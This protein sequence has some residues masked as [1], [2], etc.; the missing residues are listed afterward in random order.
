MK[1]KTYSKLLMFCAAC[2]AGPALAQ[3]NDLPKA[4]PAQGFAPTD[5][6]G[7]VPGDYENARAN[8]ST[9]FKVIT[10]YR[11]RHHGMYTAKVAALLADIA[12]APASYQFAS[13]QAANSALHNP[14]AKF[15]DGVSAEEAGA[16]WVYRLVDKRPDGTAFGTPHETGTKDL[17]AYTSA[18]I[19]QNVRYFPG[20][21][22]VAN[23]VGSYV[24]LW[25]DGSIETF[26]YDQ[27]LFAPQEDG[28]FSEVFPGQAGIPWNVLTYDEMLPGT[29]RGKPL[30]ENR[31][32]AVPDNGAP[33]ALLALSRLLGHPLDREALW[34][35]L[36]PLQEQFNPADIGNTAVQLG[37]PLQRASLSWGDLQQRP[38]PAI[39]SLKAPERLITLCSIGQDYS[40][41]LDGGMKRIVKNSALAARYKG[42]ALIVPSSQETSPL[43]IKD[44]VG[45]ITIKPADEVKQ[46]VRIVNRGQAP[47]HLDLEYPI[48]G[49]VQAHLSQ[50]SIA[51]GEETVLD[52]SFKWRPPVSGDTQ[53]D[54]ITLHTDAPGQ[55]RVQCGFVLQLEPE[56]TRK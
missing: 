16:V 40:I 22:S 28:A 39:L 24:L 3:P 8:L 47:V 38:T 54:F 27:V 17:L 21:I 12:A 33:E 20:D 43:Q 29:P 51:P 2:L 35:R 19:H 14:D 10:N 55:P 23:P 25:D 48:P 26:A 15:M 5:T 44:G 46:Q 7:L 34:K 9:L 31:T 18:Y 49:V 4:P 53:K 32:E 37:I 11:V 13:F 6:K 30:G 45:L 50:S 52:L 56:K 41:I 1:N 42:E 36:N